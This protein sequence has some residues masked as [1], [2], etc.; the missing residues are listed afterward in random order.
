MSSIQ[1]FEVEDNEAK[2][3]VKMVSG[4]EGKTKRKAGK[5]RSKC[6]PN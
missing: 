2:F 1:E 5:E 4:F 3:D 6:L